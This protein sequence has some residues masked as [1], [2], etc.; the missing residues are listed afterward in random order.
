MTDRRPRG[1]PARIRLATVICVALVAVLL[2]Q[3][4]LP[5]TANAAACPCSIWSSSAVPG[6]PSE[7]DTAAVE[8]GTKFR[9]DVDGYV[10]GVR[11]YKGTGNTGTHVGHLWATDGRNLGTVTFAG[12]TASGW[13]QATFAAPVGITANTTYIVSYYAPTGHYADDGGFFATRG[14]DNAPLHALQDG[15]DG[16]NGVY[17]YGLAGGFPTNTWQSSNYWVDV[18]FNTA[19]TDTTPP[20][21]TGTSPAANATG[22][23]AGTTISA[24]LSEPI[25]AGSARLGPTPGDRESTRLDS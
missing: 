5:Q 7:P 22:V 20:T 21:V 11:F 2:G 23:P 3:I 24:T 18:V 16:A 9:S 14:V 25:Q 8:V 1:R 4:S 6:T 10:T 15:V 13:Q 12:E 19:V 17:R